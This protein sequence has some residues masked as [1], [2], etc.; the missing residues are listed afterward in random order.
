MKG[1]GSRNMVVLQNRS[2]E[3]FACVLLAMQLHESHACTL[4]TERERNNE[5][6]QQTEYPSK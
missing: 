4:L 1:V 2:L 6:E 5:V 3:F